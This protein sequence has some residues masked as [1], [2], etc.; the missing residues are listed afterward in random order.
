VA[1]IDEALIAAMRCLLG[2]NFETAVESY[3]AQRGYIVAFSI[4]RGAYEE[5]ARVENARG[6]EIELV[7]VKDLLLGTSE[8]VAPVLDRRVL[9]LPKSRPKAAMPSAEELVE[10]DQHSRRLA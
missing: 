9:E 6:L 2:E 3:G 7:T 4:T 5:A 1:Y 8:L 10:S